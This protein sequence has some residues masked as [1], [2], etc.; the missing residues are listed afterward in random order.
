MSNLNLFA[1]SSEKTTQATPLDPTT[2][3]VPSLTV[4][5]SVYSY[6]S[7]PQ[8]AFTE[9]TTPGTAANS[10]ISLALNK[11]KSGSD[12]I[13]SFVMLPVESPQLISDAPGPWGFGDMTASTVAGFYDCTD[14]EYGGGL[15]ASLPV[16]VSGS[17]LASIIDKLSNTSY[18]VQL[19]PSPVAISAQRIG[20]KCTLPVLETT[21]KN[22][23]E[24]DAVYLGIKARVRSPYGANVKL[25]A[26]LK[27]FFVEATNALTSPVAALTAATS[28]VATDQLFDG[29]PEEYYTTPPSPSFNDMHFN[30]S[31]NT[32]PLFTGYRYF[33]LQGVT[34]A[35]YELIKQLGL[36]LEIVSNAGD[37]ACVNEG[38]FATSAPNQIAGGL[39]NAE[40]YPAGTTVYLFQTTTVPVT[41]VWSGPYTVASYATG[42]ITLTE[43]IT[44][45]AA[46]SVY[47]TK[48]IMTIDIYEACLL[49]HKS[50]SV[51]SEVYASLNG[52]TFGGPA[53]TYDGI[54]ATD[55]V[56]WSIP[57]LRSRPATA[58]MN[59]PLDMLEHCMRL[60]NWSEVAVQP[61]TA[62][63][64]YDPGA[65]IRSGSTSTADGDYNGSFDNPNF[66]VY[67]G[68]SPSTV[69]TFGQIRY[70]R[71]AFQ[72]FDDS[73]AWTETLSRALCK[74]FGILS[75]IG[76]DGYECVESF[77][78]YGTS[79]L[80]QI[81][82]AD[83]AERAGQ[84]TEPQIQDVFCEPAIEYGYDSGP[85]KY[86]KFL[87]ITNTNMATWQPAYSSG[88]SN[89]GTGYF[90]S[91][92]LDPFGLYGTG[93]P[94]GTTSVSDGQYIWTCC[95]QL[96]LK[97]GQ[98]EKCPSDFT[99]Q[100]LIS[101]YPDALYHLIY[102]LKVMQYRRIN[103]SV[104]YTK[105]RY[106][107]LFQ[108]LALQLPFL[109]TTPIECVVEKFTKNKN[110]DRV[111]LQL[112]LLGTA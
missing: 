7:I 48:Q 106:W 23:F 95:R 26:M 69:N 71:P 94:L 18:Q 27:R 112:I 15:G 90:T 59:D 14:S 97:Y 66:G 62:G 105:G 39:P 5:E 38:T 16:P 82:F 24:F 60:Q 61:I 11:I 17:T 53:G 77:V 99:E 41:K 63:K 96:C 88:F 70:C 58:M 79:G 42:S 51:K 80:P 47:V 52:R 45:I 35:N 2:G 43:N 12:D 3:G 10:A 73:K 64:S 108:H 55:G 111:K 89:T 54:D 50:V 49:F 102:K 21:I 107:H 76:P 91:G 44:G 74:A 13:D 32:T 68:A 28:I 93:K 46:G 103:V 84:V 75:Y 20:I 92:G 37:E 6:R 30:N 8:S 100:P 104:F 29:I 101:I 40:N 110:A 9:K 109:G 31:W 4:D 22:S 25:Y 1:Y 57:G 86:Q 78:P 81:A 19:I 83:L 34:Q 65:L 36:F 33:Q 72:I 98:V 56:V 67:D 85:G 87:A